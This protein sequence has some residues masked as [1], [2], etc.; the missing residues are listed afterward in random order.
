MAVSN[1]IYMLENATYSILS[2][3]GFASILWKD[4]KRADEASQVMKITAG[5]LLKLK[6]IEKV[7][8]E[9]KPAGEEN[10]SDIVGYMKCYIKE[11]LAKYKD[12][13]ESFIVNERYERFRSF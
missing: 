9:V 8:P 5:D 2:P 10:L 12:K 11:F 6:V 3:E 13:D 4:S 7:I 1:E